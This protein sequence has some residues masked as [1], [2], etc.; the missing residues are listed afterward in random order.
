MIKHT[1]DIGELSMMKMVSVSQLG[2][3][4]D[5]FRINISPV[6]GT[7]AAH[8]IGDLLMATRVGGANNLFSLAFVMIEIENSGF[9]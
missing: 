2:Y 1:D 7:D 4:D 8:L 6:F 3:I 5:N 9:Y